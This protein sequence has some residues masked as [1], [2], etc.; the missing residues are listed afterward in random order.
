MAVDGGMTDNPRY[1]MYQA[2]YDAVIA[3][4][5]DALRAEKVT[6]AGNLANQGI[7]L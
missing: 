4:K 7:F 2:K 1:A 5:P 6:I 3:N